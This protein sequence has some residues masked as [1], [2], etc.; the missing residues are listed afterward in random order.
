MN[1]FL[2]LRNVISLYAFILI[3]WG[4]YRFLFKLPDVV[5]EVVLKPILWLVPLLL[6][7]RREKQTLSSVGWTTQN[8]FKSVYLAIGLGVLFAAEGAVVNSI[9][10]GGSFN[11]IQIPGGGALLG[12]L[13]LSL[14]T[15]FSEETVFRGFIFNRLWKALHREWDANLLTSCGWALIHLPVTVFV[16][17]YDVVQAVSFLFLTFLF[18]VASAFVFART[19][20]IF[21][22]VLLHVFWE[23]PIILFR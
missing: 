21:S 2:S 5:E 20:N 13:G 10:Y 6:V 3:V 14:V 11:F 1:K 15:A 17:K 19:G 9:K 22:S 8:L 18:G 12:A 23:W 4:F 7:L 16:L